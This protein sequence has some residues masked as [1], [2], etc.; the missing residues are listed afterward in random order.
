MLINATSC[1]VVENETKNRTYFIHE[2]NQDGFRYNHKG[3]ILCNHK[4]KPG[5]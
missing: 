1:I 3:N 2:K 4:G 5:Q